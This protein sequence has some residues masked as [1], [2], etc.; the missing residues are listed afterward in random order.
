MGH[1][2]PDRVRLRGWGGGGPDAVTLTSL[3]IFFNFLIFLSSS[4][5]TP[6][7][8]ILFYIILDSPPTSSLFPV[9]RPSPHVPPP[10][11]PGTSDASG[12][13]PETRLGRRRGDGRGRS[14]LARSK[15]R[16][17][18]KIT[19]DGTY[20]L[21]SDQDEGRLGRRS[22]GEGVG[23]GGGGDG[24]GG[25]VLVVAGSGSGGGEGGVGTVGV[26]GV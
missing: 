26:T 15:N 11:E 7:L 14:G 13:R 9:L 24:K 23:R 2:S 3:K 6:F 10:A 8:Y 21:H 18:V 25:G 1:L 4:S 16:Y 12:R 5:S 17:F 20:G 22:G 19:V